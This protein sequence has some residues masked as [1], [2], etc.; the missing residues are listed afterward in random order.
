MRTVQVSAA[1]TNHTCLEQEGDEMMRYAALAL[2]LGFATPAFAGEQKATPK[3][4][5]AV[6][7]KAQ[8]KVDAPARM[9]DKQLDQVVAGDSLIEISGNK[10]NVQA[11]VTVLSN[12]TGNTNNNR[13]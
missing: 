1:E 8:L 10:V 5:T 9:T 2:A 3:Q 11:N 13:F 4:D 7:T 6:V 12:K